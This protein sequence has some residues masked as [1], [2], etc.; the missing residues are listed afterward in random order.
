MKRVV[1]VTLIGAMGPPGGG[2]QPVSNRMLR[3]MH[4]ISFTEMTSAEIE[5]IFTTI[6]S[7]FLRANFEDLMS[8]VTPLVKATVEVYT[9]T[10]DHLRPTPAHL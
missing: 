8:L 5:G 7:A 1:D 2:R 4:M 9:K 10:I 6:A 3:H